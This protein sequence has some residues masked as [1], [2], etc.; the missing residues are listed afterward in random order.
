MIQKDNH[1]LMMI[2]IISYSNPYRAT[3][4]RKL[5]RNWGDKV[6]EFSQKFR[7]I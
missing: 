2:L 3:V 6:V 1:G 5:K 7:N 4:E